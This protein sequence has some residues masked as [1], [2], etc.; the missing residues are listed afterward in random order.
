MDFKKVLAG[1]ALVGMCGGV[2]AM[3]EAIVVDSALKDIKGLK[4]KLLSEKIPGLKLKNV[5]LVD[6]KTYFDF[7][8][9]ES[10]KLYQQW[11]RELHS[12]HGCKIK[13]ENPATHTSKILTLHVDSSTASRALGKTSMLGAVPVEPIHANYEWGK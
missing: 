2:Y 1:L 7:D 11:L 12:A 5:R 13:F 3:E 9:P 10:K 6:G 8:V 4:P